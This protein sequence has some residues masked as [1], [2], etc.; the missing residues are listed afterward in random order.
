MKRT[1]ALLILTKNTL[2]KQRSRE[3]AGKF[4]H[5][6]YDGT[7]FTSFNRQQQLEFL[8]TVSIVP[9][10]GHCGHAQYGSINQRS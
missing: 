6:S 3:G 4:Y 9:P 10:S 2:L 7:N 5:G 1:W 8:W